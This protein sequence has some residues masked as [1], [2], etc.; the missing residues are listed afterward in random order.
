MASTT[1]TEIMC[2]SPEAPEAPVRRSA[3]HGGRRHRG[4]RPR[5]RAS[6]ARKQESLP[7]LGKLKRW[8]EGVE[9]AFGPDEEMAKAVQY[10][11]NHWSALTRFV[12]DGA[13]PPTNNP[14]RATPWGDRPRSEERPVCG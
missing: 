14:G 12:A 6:G 2:S 1:S 10:C 7:T 5:R 11:R 13:I 9:A 3:W 8:M 4:R